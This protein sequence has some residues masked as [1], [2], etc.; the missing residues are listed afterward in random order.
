MSI[1]LRDSLFFGTGSAKAEIGNMKSWSNP[2]SEISYLF[3]YTS[4][5]RVSASPLR[6]SSI[7]S[8]RLFCKSSPRTPVVSRLNAH[9]FSRP[10]LCQSQ[11]YSGDTSFVLLAT[12]VLHNSSPVGSVLC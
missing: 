2:V 1:L 3:L 10:R 7:Y 9:P 8:Q 12:V 5:L 6:L 11:K 4:L